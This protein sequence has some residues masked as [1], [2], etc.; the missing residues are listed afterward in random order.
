MTAPAEVSFAIVTRRGPELLADCLASLA[1]LDYPSERIEILVHDNASRSGLADWLYAHYPAIRLE[2][3]SQNLGF[4]EPC[5]RLA[6]SAA[7]GL[8]CFINDDMTFDPGFLRSLLAAREAT[9]AA[10]V[11]AAILDREGAVIEFAGG[12]LALSGHGAP[13]HL[14]QPASCLSMLA[15]AEESLFV[16][17]GAMLVDRAIFLGLGGFDAAYFAYYEDVD[18][19]WRL[20]LAGEHAVVA[21]A[22]RCF[23][24]GHASESFLG[25]DG[26]MVLLERNALLSVVKNFEE[27]RVAAVFSYALALSEARGRFAPERAAACEHGR[28]AALAALPAAE[29]ARRRFAASRRLGDADLLPL[30]GDPWRAEIADPRYALLRDQL[31]ADFGLMAFVE[32]TRAAG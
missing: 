28:L 32:G 30:F 14:G 1:A 17:G 19:G 15:E 13:R 21:P 7:A 10:C 29:R 9:G 11:G 18:F 24:R 16:S 3:S 31:A 6:Q 20:H 23:H 27:D 2:C 12:S 26:R 25:T 8:V 5:N 22:A 4:A